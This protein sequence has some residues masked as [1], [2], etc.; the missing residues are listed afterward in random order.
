M[1]ST[2]GL[3]VLMAGSLVGGLSARADDLSAAADKAEIQMLKARLDKLE[4]KMADR[5]SQDAGAAPGTAALQLPSGLQGVHMSGFV[6]TQYT[7]NFNAPE[8]T[9]NTLRVFDTQANSFMINNAQLALEKPVSSESPVGFKT[10][11]MF[12]TD[13]EVVGSVTGGL[14]TTTSELELQEAYGEYLAPVGNGLDLKVGKFATLHGA[15]VIESKDNWNISRSFLFGYA[16]PFTHTGVR[17]A[18]PVSDALT[19]LGGVSN[20]W[21]VVDDTNQAK[22]LE[23]GI[24][25][26]PLTG[27]TLGS[28]FMSGAEQ[29]GDNHHGRRLIDVVAGWHPTEPLQLKLNYDYGWEDDPA[30][31]HNNAVWQGI[32]GYARYAVTDKAVVSLRSEFFNDPDGV[33]TAFTSGINGVTDNNLQLFEITLTGE[34]QFNPH[35]LGRLEYRHDK[36]DASVYRRQDIG[37]VSTQD[38]VAMEFIAPF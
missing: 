24:A 8:T 9:T 2:V 6:D 1:R 14:G 12:G 18:Y 30:V 11:L 22:T 32:A 29:A 5:A 16:I 4:A 35:F 19:V 27:V 20:G 33:R 31:L 28:T 15:E 34:Y 7:Y 23:L 38:T 36:A 13:A 37:Q 3:A 26:T 17:A 21:D 10:E 25:S